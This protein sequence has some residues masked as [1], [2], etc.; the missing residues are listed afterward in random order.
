MEEDLKGLECGL[1]VWGSGVS[2]YR[3][4][5]GVPKYWP[6]ISD[7]ARIVKCDAWIATLSTVFDRSSDAAMATIADDGGEL[8]Y[9]RV[10]CQFGRM[11]IRDTAI[12][13]DADWQDYHFNELERCYGNA[14]FYDFVKEIFSSVVGNDFMTLGFLNLALTNT[15]L[16][17][18]VEDGSWMGDIIRDDSL[19]ETRGKVSSEVW[20]LRLCQD[21]EATQYLCSR[22]MDAKYFKLYEQ[23]GITCIP[24]EDDCRP[25]GPRSWRQRSSLSILDMMAWLGP[26]FTKAIVED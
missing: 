7:I 24:D 5:V 20:A 22:D 8:F 15:V 19:I 12:R 10:P 14:N 3:V 11:P 21:V 9:L 23:H 25:Y 17:L 13:P 16:S 1:D 6:T 18:L 4:C 2:E 26:E